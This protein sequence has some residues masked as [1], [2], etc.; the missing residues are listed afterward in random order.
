LF[1]FFEKVWA[2]RFLKVLIH[3]KNVIEEK[4]YTEKKNQIPHAVNNLGLP[5]LTHLVYSSQN[6]VLKV[7]KMFRATNMSGVCG[8]S[9]CI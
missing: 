2:A 1:F 5:Y 8:I 7:S 3:R 4:V 9:G 6:F